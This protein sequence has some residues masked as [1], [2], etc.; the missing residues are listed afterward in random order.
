LFSLN[1]T[2]CLGGSREGNGTRDHDFLAGQGGQKEEPRISK[3]SIE[4][5]GKI[6]GMLPPLRVHAE[7]HTRGRDTCFLLNLGV[8]W[9]HQVDPHKRIGGRKEKKILASYGVPRK[10]NQKGSKMA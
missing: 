9:K 7:K 2:K 6:Q 4:I 1:V 10:R 3:R 8:H 5:G